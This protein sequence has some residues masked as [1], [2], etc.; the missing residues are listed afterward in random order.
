MQSA[1]CLLRRANLRSQAFQLQEIVDGRLIE[2]RVDRAVA[3]A[4]RHVSGRVLG[5]SSSSSLAW[6][7]S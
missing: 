6:S 2:N 7:R 4:G 5:E 3:S 1:I